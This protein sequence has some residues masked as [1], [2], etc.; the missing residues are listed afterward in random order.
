MAPQP[1]TISSHAVPP[2]VFPQ[3][4]R[5]GSC[6]AARPCT[7]RAPRLVR[8]NVLFRDVCPSA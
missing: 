2:R 3:V 8:V 6:L 4:L 7:H 5:F 1:A